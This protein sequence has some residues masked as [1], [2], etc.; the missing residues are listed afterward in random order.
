[1][2]TKQIIFNIGKESYG[3]D[4][5]KICEIEKVNDIVYI[6]DAPGCILGIMNLRGNIIPVYSLRHRFNKSGN[7]EKDV[8]KGS[9]KLIVAVSKGME[10]GFVVDSVDGIIEIDSSH[11]FDAPE[12]LKTKQT[13][14][15]DKVA[16][17]DDRIIILL[18]V[19]AVVNDEEREDIA[20]IIDK[21]EA[22]EI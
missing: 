9:P 4:I 14:Y 5:L 12:I 2:Q 3:I 21:T 15:I 20:S 7:T 18:D 13:C 10:I 19:D 1:M 16:C 6:P 8:K 17:V 11:M 22:D